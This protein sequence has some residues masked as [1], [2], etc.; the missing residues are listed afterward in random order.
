M[1]L[2]SWTTVTLF[3][4]D[5]EW[6]DPN[7]LRIEMNNDHHLSGDVSVELNYKGT[8]FGYIAYPHQAVRIAVETLM[9]LSDMAGN[10]DSMIGP[11]D[12]PNKQIP[13]H[14]NLEGMPLLPDELRATL[15]QY[16]AAVEAWDRDASDRAYTGS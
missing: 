13:R 12:D 14:R 2:W 9:M 7:N 10:Q 16:R 11:R 1:A 3:D 4:D 8:A 15:D 6:P 5:D